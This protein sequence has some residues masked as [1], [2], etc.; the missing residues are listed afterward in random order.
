MLHGDAVAL[1]RVL[2]N[3]LDNA[4]RHASSRVRIEVRDGEATVIDDG[5]GFAMDDEAR[6]Q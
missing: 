5:P 2:T 3:L 4:V 1:E 6:C